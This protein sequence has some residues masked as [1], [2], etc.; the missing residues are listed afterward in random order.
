MTTATPSRYRR[1]SILPPRAFLAAL[2]SQL[3]LVAADWP[4]RPAMVEVVAG[5]VLI[6]AGAMLNVWSERLFRRAEVGV[7][8]FSPAPVLVV[9][10]PFALSRNPMYLGLVAISAGLAITTGV[11]ANLWITT[12]LAVWLHY[13]YVLPEEAFLRDRFVAEFE[14]YA[15]RVPRWVLIADR[16]G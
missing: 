3:P 7:C 5:A 14:Q 8:P 4:L 2:L 16:N 1:S 9:R 11:L 13:A 6:M 10:G 15:R 12:T